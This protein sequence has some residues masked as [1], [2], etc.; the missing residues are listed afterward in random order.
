MKPSK[1]PRGDITF[2]DMKALIALMRALSS[3]ETSVNI[4][5]TTWSNFPEDSHLHKENTSLYRGSSVA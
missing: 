2:T 5:Q 4:Y 1:P 3:S